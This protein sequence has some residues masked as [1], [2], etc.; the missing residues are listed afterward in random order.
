VKF[1]LEEI[2]QPPLSSKQKSKNALH[3]QIKI[4]SNIIHIVSMHGCS[5]GRAGEHLPTRA[6]Q[7]QLYLFIPNM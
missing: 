6:P 5:E 7:T 2:H 1:C 4:A 3:V